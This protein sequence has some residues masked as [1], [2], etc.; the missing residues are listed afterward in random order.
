MSFMKDID[1]IIP[2]GIALKRRIFLKLIFLW[3][4]LI[5]S[6]KIVVLIAYNVVMSHILD[7]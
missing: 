1:E 5:K 3:D 7:S 6:V 2:W 4:Y